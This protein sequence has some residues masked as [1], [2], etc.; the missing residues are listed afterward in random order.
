MCAS[1]IQKA[2]Y[3]YK[4]MRKLRAIFKNLKRMQN[5]WKVRTE[6]K[7]FI[8]TRRK[9]IKLQRWIRRRLYKINV[10]QNRKKV[11][12][13][14]SYIRKYLASRFS[15]NEITPKVNKLQNAFKRC[16]QKIMKFK[17]IKQ[18]FMVNI[19][20]LTIVIYL[21]KIEIFDLVWLKILDR[22][23]TIIQKYIRGKVIRIRHK[24]IIVK[25]KQK[26]LSL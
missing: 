8:N 1:R 4:Q 17:K 18:F 3:R 21:S 20:I 13:I 11:M 2:F 15:L 12:L 14:Q 9:V 6:H 26:G 24:D 23:A 7:N 5:L 25:A 10:A 19:K 22:R 16:I